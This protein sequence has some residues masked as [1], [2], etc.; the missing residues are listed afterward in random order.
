M[1]Q[2]FLN[3][4]QHVCEEKR[5]GN[6]KTII[7]TETKTEFCLV[8][9]FDENARRYGWKRENWVKKKDVGRRK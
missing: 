6:S 4:S 5:V 3:D 1:L 2:H 9:Y 7:D 8:K